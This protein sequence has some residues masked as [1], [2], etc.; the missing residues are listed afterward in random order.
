MH[1]LTS[2]GRKLAGLLGAGYRSIAMSGAVASRNKQN[3]GGDGGYDW[4]LQ[5]VRRPAR[6]NAP[7]HPRSQ[8]V[9]PDF[10]WN[11]I[12]LLG[13][14]DTRPLHEALRAI[15]SRYR[16][17]A[18]MEETDPSVTLGGG[19]AVSAIALGS[20]T[21]F[22]GA[23]AAGD[24]TIAVPS[25]YDGRPIALGWI[26]NPTLAQAQAQIRVDGQVHSTVTIDHAQMASTGA[27]LNGAVTRLTDLAPG[28]HTV[29]VRWISGSLYFDYWALEARDD[30]GPIVLLP[31]QARLASYAVYAGYTFPMNDAAVA[32]LHDDIEDVA[33]EFGETVV[34]VDL[35][36]AMHPSGTPTSDPFLADQVHPNEE[37]HAR[38]AKALYGA[39]IPILSRD[40]VL[41]TPDPGPYFNPVWPAGA[42]SKDCKFQNGWTNLGG[43]FNDAG[44]RM[45]PNGEVELRGVVTAG[46]TANAVMFTL[47]AG[48][49]PQRAEVRPGIG[50]NVLARI[51]I[52]VD[53]TVRAQAGGSTAYT[54]LDGI[55]FPSIAA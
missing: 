50:N 30:E 7:Y 16:S 2:Y 18:V 55:R 20:G 33:S 4:V 51:D 25:S 41:G 37:G 22:A 19:W 44:Y 46:S 28:A 11:D 34:A 32:V 1:P 35:E 45:H 23:S 14:N 8:V 12:A 42:T 15:V 27:L 36:A 31:M 9:I 24:L 26:T 39:L 47:P 6:P 48:Y 40:R 17:V 49:R 3:A 38:I 21:G 5:N 43:G 52:G 54:I 10:G 29:V 13:V 53:G